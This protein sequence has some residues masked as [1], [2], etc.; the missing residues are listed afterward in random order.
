[1]IPIIICAVASGIITLILIGPF[2]HKNPRACYA[3]MVFIPVLSVGA[4]M[5][6]AQPLQQPA[7][8]A[9]KQALHQ[10]ASHTEQSID[11]LEKQK[12]ELRQKLK[13]DKNNI[14]AIK[15]LAG[16]YIAQAQFDEAINLL[17]NAHKN[18]PHNTDLKTQLSTAHFAQGLLYAENFDYENALVSLNTAQEITPDAP[19]AKDLEKFISI[20]EL[21]KTN[22]L[23]VDQKNITINDVINDTEE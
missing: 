6:V 22:N 18:A 23:Q 4:Y 9:L 16:I 1:M 12:Q 3:L 8:K 11:I 15:Q 5:M 17:D 2:V 14:D 10:E 20:I 13:E 21:R 7:E 19:F